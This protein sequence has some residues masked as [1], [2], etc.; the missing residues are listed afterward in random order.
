[1][2]SIDLV[3]GRKIPNLRDVLEMLPD[4]MRLF[5]E[6]KC[7]WE[8]GEAGNVFPRLSDMI[9]ATGTEDRAVIISFNPEKL[10]DAYRYLPKI[11]RY[12]LLWEKE[13]PREMVQAALECHADGINMQFAL[14]NEDVMREARK[15]NL[16]VYVWTLYAPE[17]ATKL[18]NNYGKIDGITTNFPHKMLKE[19]EAND[20][21]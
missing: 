17:D 12:L 14:L 1:L 13:S 20:Y 10:V 6:I 15:S 21:R 2:R 11:S 18:I 5:I 19:I 7:C 3:H 16:E 4:D 9:K 8:P